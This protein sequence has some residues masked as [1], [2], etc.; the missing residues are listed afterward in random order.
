MSPVMYTESMF[1]SLSKPLHTVSK[2]CFSVNA[3]QLFDR[4]CYSKIDYKIQQTAPVQE[5]VVRFSAFDVGCLAVTDE[6]DKLVGIFSEGDFIKRVASVGKDSS[7]V[8][9]KDVCTLAPNILI[10]KPDDSLEYCMSMM[11]VK[12]IRHLAI[13]DQQDLQG[14][15]S[16]KDLFAATIAQNEELIARLADFKIGKGAYFGSE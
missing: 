2:R 8:Q 4:S 5:A 7:N 1:R 3:A 10:A 15:I 16:I 12:N 6:D 13:V 11:H 9:I 14:L